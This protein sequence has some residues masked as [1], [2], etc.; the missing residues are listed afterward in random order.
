M[1][2]YN[3]FRQF[4]FSEIDHN[5][6]KKNTGVNKYQKYFEQF[7]YII[8]QFYVE[9]IRILFNFFDE[10]KYTIKT[11]K[12]CTK[13]LL[14]EMINAVEN[15]CDILEITEN[16]LGERRLNEENMNDGIY[17]WFIKIKT[18]PSL[19]NLNHIGGYYNNI[20]IVEPTYTP[21]YLIRFDH[22]NNK[23]KIPILL[24]LNGKLYDK[25]WYSS[26]KKNISINE[27]YN[28]S[29]YYMKKLKSS[30]N[31]GQIIMSYNGWLVS[32]WT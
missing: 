24:L 20:N 26:D 18:K 2:K 23:Y 17:E 31:L 1:L 7:D 30:L 27:I 12:K 32:L 29:I 19:Q 6:Y 13:Y 11:K 21:E 25:I 10:S 4:T 14:T 16:W 15:N 5:I 9:H 8:G 22:D 28:Y 3:K